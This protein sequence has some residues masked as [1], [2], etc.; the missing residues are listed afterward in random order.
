MGPELVIRGGRVIDPAQ[1]IDRRLDVVVR[2]GRIVELRE[3][4]ATDAGGATD[5]GG[6][7]TVIDAAGA[8]VVPGLI[9][10]HGHFYEGSPFG[11]DARVNLRG[12][13][14]TAVDAGSSGYSNFGEFRRYGIASAPMRLLAF[15]HIAANGLSTT[16]VPEL[17]D[18][19]FARTAEAEQVI[20]ANPDSIV[21]V[22]VRTGTGGSGDNTDAALAAALRVAERTGV[23]LM[24]HISVG[25]SVGQ[26]VRQLRAG[27]IVTHCFTGGGQAIFDPATGHVLAEV[28]QARERG[29]TFDVGHGCGSFSWAVAQRALEQ[30]FPPDTA[31]TDLHRL[32][33]ETPV[34]DLPTTLAKLMHLGMSLGDVIAAATGKAAAALG[35]SDE[36]GTLAVGRHAD[37]A[38][39]RMDE[40]AVQLRDAVNVTRTASVGLR[41]EWTV[42]AGTA[43]RVS[44]VEIP[45][46]ALLASD[47][48]AGCG[49][50]IEA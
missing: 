11:I 33:V 15:L 37:I 13:V 40:G 50:P 28:R 14:T 2:D 44:D 42:V 49:G 39:L 45:L 34:V 27:D 38:V 10:L 31:G 18:I 23:R 21:G 47:Y 48:E 35:R 8:L 30:G 25:S 12:G 19:R 26:I 32:A 20:R 5:G 4:S 7:S 24:T 43:H 41:A 36:M 46:R 16:F 22:K 6:Q 3:P 17:A 9:D 1:G 29:V